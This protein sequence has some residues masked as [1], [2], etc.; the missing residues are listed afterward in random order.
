MKHTDLT[1][2]KVRITTNHLGKVFTKP[3]GGQFTLH[4][5]DLGK[6]LVILPNG[7]AYVFMSGSY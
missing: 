6:M 5:G 4:K 2:N 7:R 3:E 1:T